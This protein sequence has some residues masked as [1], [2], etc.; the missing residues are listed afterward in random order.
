MRV[1]RTRRARDGIGELTGGLG[2]EVHGVLVAR[3]L[4][5]GRGMEASHRR[6]GAFRRAG[7]TTQTNQSAST[8]ARAPA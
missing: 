5:L 3:M 4:P 2:G 8:A 1:A 7:P 6:G